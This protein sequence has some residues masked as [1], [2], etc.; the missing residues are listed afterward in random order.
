MKVSGFRGEPTVTTGL[1]ID[2]R[3]GPMG[4]Q[5]HTQK[6]GMVIK[7]LALARVVM[8]WEAQADLRATVQ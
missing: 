8:L 4:P 7:P 1:G 5:T 3:G 2:L 6:N